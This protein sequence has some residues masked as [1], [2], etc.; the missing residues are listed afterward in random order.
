VFRL[1]LGASADRPAL[2]HM[3][4][5]T[6]TSVSPDGKKLFTADRDEKIRVSDVA[7][8]FVIDGYCLGHKK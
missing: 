3:S 6:A 1:Q 7:R 4:S 2:G 5:I 8:P